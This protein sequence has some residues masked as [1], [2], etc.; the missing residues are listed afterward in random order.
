ME[1]RDSLAV[2]DPLVL[3]EGGENLEI[4]DPQESPVHLDQQVATELRASVVI[5]VFLELTDLPDLLDS[6]VAMETMEIRDT[7]DLVDCRDPL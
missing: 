5:L 2:P 7:P 3:P 4:A 1:T 6:P